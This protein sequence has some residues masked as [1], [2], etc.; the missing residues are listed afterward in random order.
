MLKL[1]VN[2]D[3]LWSRKW[4]LKR[5]LEIPIRD[6]KL[7][8]VLQKWAKNWI[9]AKTWGKKQWKEIVKI[10]RLVVNCLTCKC[11]WKIAYIQLR[12]DGIKKDTEETLK[13]TNFP[14]NGNAS[15]LFPQLYHIDSSTTT[16]VW[17]N[18]TLNIDNN[19]D[20]RKIYSFQK[21]SR[22]GC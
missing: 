5:G 20:L 11:R 6:K 13:M 12:S 16:K 7:E 1:L 3:L 21:Q 18:L 22:A 2:Q 19:E 17:Q 8:V 4:M 9:C 14:L 10:F 15:N